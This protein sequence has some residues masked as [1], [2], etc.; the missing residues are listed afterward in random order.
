MMPFDKP[1]DQISAE[2]IQDL[3]TIQATETKTLEFKRQFPDFKTDKAKIEFLHDITA[4]ANTDGGIIIYGIEEKNGHASSI[5][6]IDASTDVLFRQIN[7]IVKSHIK[8]AVAPVELRELKI[9][10]KKIYLVRVSQSYNKP[11]MVDYD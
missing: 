9:D 3:I 6:N 2:D 8:P 5:Y 10:D 7:D 11:H 4:F 1:F